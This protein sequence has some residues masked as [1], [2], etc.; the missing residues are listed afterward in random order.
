MGQPFDPALANGRESAAFGVG[1]PERAAVDA[2]LVG[3]P[4]VA[5]AFADAEVLGH[6]LLANGAPDD[7]D[8]ITVTSES[9]VGFRIGLDPEETQGD[10]LVGLFAPSFE[11]AE[12]DSLRFQIWELGEVVVDETFTD[13]AVALA[14]FGDHVLDLGAFDA[15]ALS[16]LSL[17]FVFEL[18]SDDPGARFTTQLVFASVPEPGTLSLLAIGLALVSARARALPSR[19]R[20]R[21]RPS[22]PTA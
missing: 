1:L 22:C 12:L 19:S 16:E 5:A 2:A 14:F 4:E 13:A 18:T 8:G 6:V 3:S 7:G 10:L 9:S 11:G 21:A 15:S 17:G 20:G